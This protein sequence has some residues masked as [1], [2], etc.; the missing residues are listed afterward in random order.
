[1]ANPQR[2]IID[3]N[4]VDNFSEMNIDPV[5]AFANSGYTLYI[6]KDVKREIEALISAVDKRLEHS[7]DEQKQRDCQKRELAIRILQYAQ[8]RNSGNHPRFGGDGIDI[9][10]SDK[11]ENASKEGKVRPTGIP[12]NRTDNDL[13]ML[14]RRSWVLTANYKESHWE[15]AQALPFLVQWFTL[16]EKL[17]AN[18][19]DLVAA[20]DE[21]Y[22]ERME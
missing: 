22:K 13:V 4:M 6:T 2:V 20:L 7:D 17:L 8:V 5:N 1:M 9:R 21:T 10:A 19:G 14:A 12:V 15:K 18:G 11:D 3:S 16:K